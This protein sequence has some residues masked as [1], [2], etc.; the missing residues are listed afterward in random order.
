VHDESGVVGHS[1]TV[2]RRSEHVDSV[3]DL[4]DWFVAESS[5][6]ESVQPNLCGGEKRE[7][8]WRRHPCLVG[9]SWVAGHGVIAS[10]RLLRAL[11]LESPQV[12][13]VQ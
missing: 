13:L 12:Y 7:D 5:A 6:A 9:S 1:E 4:S 11:W 3:T 2:L 10:H 8:S